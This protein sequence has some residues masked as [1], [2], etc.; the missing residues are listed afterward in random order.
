MTEG[1]QHFVYILFS[2]K[3]NRYYI[4]YSSDP[5]KRL[6]ERHNQ[7]YVKAT[8]NCKPYVLKKMKSF[9][10]EMEAINEERRIK[11]YKSRTYL[12][13]LIIENW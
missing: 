7:G 13:K 11:S 5:E 9:P 3:C 1:L 10:S 6:Q 2:E 4:G 8:R 12:E